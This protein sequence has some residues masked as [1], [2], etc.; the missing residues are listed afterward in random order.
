[1]QQAYDDEARE[2]EIHIA[3]KL[4]EAFDGSESKGIVVQ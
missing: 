1:M 3:A 4:S 2:L